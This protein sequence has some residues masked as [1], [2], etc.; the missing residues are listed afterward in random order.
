[1]HAVKNL[2][3]KGLPAPPMLC[4]GSKQ[5]YR[6]IFCGL[7]P[8]QIGTTAGQKKL[9]SICAGSKA[10][11]TIDDGDLKPDQITEIATQLDVSEDDFDEPTDGRQ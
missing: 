8:C 6:N 3:Q 11:L 10:R 1:M 5:P 7:G 2:N 4:G 9:F